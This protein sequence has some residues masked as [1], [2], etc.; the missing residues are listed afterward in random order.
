MSKPSLERRGAHRTKLSF[1]EFKTKTLSYLQTQNIAPPPH[2]AQSNTRNRSSSRGKVAR[3]IPGGSRPYLSEDSEEEYVIRRIIQERELSISRVDEVSISKE[4]SGSL[5]EDSKQD[6]ESTIQ[7]L[8]QREVRVGEQKTLQRRQVCMQV[9]AQLSGDKSCSFSMSQFEQSSGSET[10][11][12]SEAVD[13]RNAV[14]AVVSEVIKEQGQKAKFSEALA[15]VKGKK[16]TLLVQGRE[17]H[18][19]YYQTPSN[20]QLVYAL[21]RCPNTIV[22]KQIR[23][24]YRLLASEL[25]PLSL[26]QISSADAV[27]M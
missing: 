8:K 4:A 27:S 23:K 25:S 26:S 3:V 19:V 10:E 24:C 9:L 17:I 7:Q 13:G 1:D 16:I 5:E 15:G 6:F 18:G 11:K 14:I 21:R 2:R 12:P 20:L 22:F